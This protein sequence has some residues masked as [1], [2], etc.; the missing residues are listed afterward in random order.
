MASKLIIP[1]DNK[2]VS[3]QQA[4]GAGTYTVP[5]GKYAKVT[6]QANGWARGYNTIYTAVGGAAT[7][8]SLTC[9]NT[10]N[11]FN[12]TME[13][14]LNPGE[15]VVLALTDASANDS[16][17]I[18]TAST[19]TITD[20]ASC[21]SETYAKITI[22]SVDFYFKAEASSNI[23]GTYTH[24]GSGGSSASYFFAYVDGGSSCGYV[25]QEYAVIS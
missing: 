16:I 11:S 12:E 20:F 3:V 24:T 21:K 7:T 9:S 2:P 4:A 15:T 25:A 22:N 19:T 6:I 14:W 8:S 17:G 18:T 23:G 1:F 13:V 5:A 10:S